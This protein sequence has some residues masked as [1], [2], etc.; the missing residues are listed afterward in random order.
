MNVG[1]CNLAAVPLR[2]ASSHRSEMVNQVL[3]GEQCEVIRQEKEWAYVRLLDTG[4]EGWLLQGQFVQLPSETFSTAAD[5]HF[6][7]DLGGGTASYE[8]K[9]VELV[10][11]TKIAISLVEQRN[12]A[13]PYHIEGD[14]R[15]LS[16]TDFD[17]EFPKLIDYYHNSPYLWGGRTRSGIDCS[18]L[19]QALYTHFGVALPRDA[20]QQA[21]HGKTIESLSEIKRGDLAFFDNEEG[22]ITHVGIMIDAETIFHASV[23]VRI[24]KMDA[25]GIFNREQNRYTHRLRN[26]KRFL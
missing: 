11:G 6:I 4:Y 9:K 14:L 17:I 10:P 24:D 1:I 19:S 20:Y 26:V 3:F 22:R 2:A 7:V 13:F 8:D 18:G 5:D 12:S 21:E 16:A 25:E 23:S 15:R